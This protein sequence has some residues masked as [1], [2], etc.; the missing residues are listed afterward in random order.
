MWKKYLLFTILMSS[1]LAVIGYMF[2]T[3]EIKYITPTPKPVNY[4]EIPLGEEIKLHESIKSKDGK[5]MST[6]F[7]GHHFARIL[8]VTH[9]TPSE[10]VFEIVVD[11]P[12]MG[13]AIYRSQRI[14]SLYP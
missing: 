11:D 2:W 14:P 5:P 1:I 10:K 4:V 3:M 7:G 9:D 13:W 8:E 12:A 6:I